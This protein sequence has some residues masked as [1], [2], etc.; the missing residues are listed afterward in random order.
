MVHVRPIRTS[1][2]IHTQMGKSSDL[3]E[4]S[5]LREVVAIQCTCCSPIEKGLKHVQGFHVTK[6]HVD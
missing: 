4:R 2:I 6:P 3:M 5:R 1:F